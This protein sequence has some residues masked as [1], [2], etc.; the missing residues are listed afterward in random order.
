MLPLA[1]D[2]AGSLLAKCVAVY[3]N[4]LAINKLTSSLKK[5]NLYS[6]QE[7]STQFRRELFG[8][9]HLLAF[10]LSPGQVDKIWQNVHWIKLNHISKQN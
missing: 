8:E 1:T 2:N 5:L 6:N 10:A 9:E 7:E 3:S 4:T